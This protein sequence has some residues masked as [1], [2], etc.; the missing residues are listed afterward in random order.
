MIADASTGKHGR[1]MPGTRI[2]IVSPDE[3]VAARPDRVLLF[4]SDLLPEVRRAMPGIEQ[5]GGKWVVV[6]PVPTEIDA[7]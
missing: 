1:T 4:I 7:Q 2:P 6:D 5:S 3:L